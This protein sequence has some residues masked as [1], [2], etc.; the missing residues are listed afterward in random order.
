[1]WTYNYPLR[2]HNVKLQLISLESG[3]EASKVQELGGTVLWG[4]VDRYV[5]QYISNRPYI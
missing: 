3:E 2:T 4:T 5:I 1:M